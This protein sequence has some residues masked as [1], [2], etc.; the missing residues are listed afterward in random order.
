MYIAVNRTL[1][2]R[3][4]IYN[5]TSFFSNLKRRSISSIQLLPTTSIDHKSKRIAFPT[6]R[7]YRSFSSN[8]D[9]NKQNKAS[10][11]MSDSNNKY[12][13]ADQEA[14]FSKAKQENNQRYLDITT[15]YNGKELSGKKVLVTGGNRGLG[16]ELVKELVNVGAKPVV[17]CRSS[18]DELEQ[19]AGKCQVYKGVDVTD[20]DAVNK[21]AQN[22]AKDGGG[23]EIVINNA[24]YFPDIFESVTK[25]SLNFE[26]E[27]KQINI[28]ALGPLR[29]NA[30][31]V[32][33]KA[34]ADG[35]KLIMITSQAGSLEWRTTQNAEKG[36]DYG[37]HM[38]RAACNMAGVLQAEEFKPLGY[39]VVLLH[40][41]F[42]RTQMTKKL[43]EVWDREGAVEPHIGAKR[44]LYETIQAD[45]SQTGTFKNCEDGL[46]IPW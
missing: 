39:T 27:L 13:M 10:T 17:V 22:I 25:D 1:L 42:N 12:S 2:N 38:S 5:N 40:P 19:L 30:A 29:V 46:M 44:V 26:E 36:G 23:V 45:F 18:S 34:L 7:Q 35:A 6:I 33:A 43:E 15:V 14:R 28:C 41:G 20:T 9:Q 32:N 11:N 8:T 3:T 24:G 37:H 16:L 21:A 31:L 4:S